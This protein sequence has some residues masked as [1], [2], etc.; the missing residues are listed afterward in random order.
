MNLQTKKVGETLL[1][2]VIHNFLTH[3]IKS[4][5]LNGGKECK[6]DLEMEKE[7]LQVFL[8]LM[9]AQYVRPLWHGRR[10]S[11][12]PFPLIPSA[13][14]RDRFLRWQ[15]WFVF[16][17][18]W[19]YVRAVPLYRL[20]HRIC[21]SWKDESSLPSQKWIWHSVAAMGGNEL[22][23]WRVKCYKMRTHTALCG[24]KKNWIFCPSIGRISIPFRYPSVPILWNCQEIT[25]NPVLKYNHHMYFHPSLHL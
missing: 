20:C 7:T 21:L 6:C 14:C 1:C 4:V 3:F 15:R 12:N 11:D 23:A 25:Y 8:Y 22:S 9:C 18:L 24:I 5:R 19:G 17:F 13:A 10:Q 2:R 16:V